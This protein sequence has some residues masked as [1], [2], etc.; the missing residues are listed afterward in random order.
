MVRL[1]L[2]AEVNEYLALNKITVDFTHTFGII[3]TVDDK[4]MWAIVKNRLCE[5]MFA[6]GC[7][8][9]TVTV[10]FA[11]STKNYV[12][13]LDEPL[14]RLYLI[15]VCGGTSKKADRSKNFLVCV[16]ANS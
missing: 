15:D 1:Q 8:Y 7:G 5:I 9:K 14:R 10:L 2:I 4:E 12:F 13:T 16:D 6:F 11:A 3:E